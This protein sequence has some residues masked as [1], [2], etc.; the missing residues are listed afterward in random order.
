MQNSLYAPLN[1]ECRQIRLLSLLPGQG[2]G[3]IQCQLSL[4]SL[5]CEPAFEALSYVWGKPNQSRSI[6]VNDTKFQITE[7]LYK[8]LMRIRRLTEKRILWVDQACIN[9]IDNN[10]RGQQVAL[11]GNIYG[12]SLRA[13][14]WLG[15]DPSYHSSIPQLCLSTKI[16]FCGWI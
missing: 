12:N 5:D 14:L 1:Q 7:N 2:S 9:Q 3:K 13:L 10:E 15:D 8:A 16:P 6:F 11:M 4:V